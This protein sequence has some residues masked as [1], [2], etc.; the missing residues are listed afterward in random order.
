MK[1][2]HTLKQLSV[3]IIH[4]FIQEDARGSPGIGGFRGR[5]S[6]HS[7]CRCYVPVFCFVRLGL[8]LVYQSFQTC[9]YI[10]YLYKTHFPSVTRDIIVEPIHKDYKQ[11]LSGKHNIDKSPNWIGLKMNDLCYI[12]PRSTDKRSS[13]TIPVW[14][15]TSLNSGN[16][17]PLISWPYDSSPNDHNL[18]PGA[19]T[20]ILFQLWLSEASFLRLR[21]DWN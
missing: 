2:N 18:R 7:S 9:A 10:K 20:Y 11:T 19:T 13:Q 21:W 8:T 4:C 12:F 16:R 14:H 17:E 6:S 15:M 5:V 1:S 3:R